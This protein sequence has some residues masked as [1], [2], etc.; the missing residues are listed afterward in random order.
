MYS[1]TKT[2]KDISEITEETVEYVGIEEELPD[3]KPIEKLMNKDENKRMRILPEGFSTD[4]KASEITT[5]KGMGLIYEIAEELYIKEKTVSEIEALAAPPFRRNFDSDTKQ[6]L[7]RAASR[8]TGRILSDAGTAAYQPTFLPEA[9]YE[10]S[11]KP[12][13][14]KQALLTE[15]LLLIPF[16]NIA[17]AVFVASDK[18]ANKSLRSFCR[19]FLIITGV[20][21]ILLTG[22]L[23]GLMAGQ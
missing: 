15:L 11:S 9:I 18:S 6:R 13:E 10:E 8:R 23:L 22:V 2:K 3:E 19:A 12:M 21:M 5:E 17:V 7:D 1:E 4:I 16:I 14:T 20:V